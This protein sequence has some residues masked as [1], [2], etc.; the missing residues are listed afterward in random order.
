MTGDEAHT[1]T[2]PVEKIEK[3][4]ELKVTRSP[5]GDIIEQSVSGESV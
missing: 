5:E 4:P 1:L 2:I 3:M